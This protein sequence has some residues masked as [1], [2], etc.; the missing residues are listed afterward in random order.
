MQGLGHYTFEYVIC[1]LDQSDSDSN[2]RQIFASQAFHL[3][4][5]PHNR[6]GNIFTLENFSAVFNDNTCWFFL[7]P[8]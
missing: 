4:Y 5:S 3:S 2:N 7:C 6:T 8:G 1:F